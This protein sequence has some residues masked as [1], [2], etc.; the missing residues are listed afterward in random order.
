M[1]RNYNYPVFCV[2]ILLTCIM[3]VRRRE[4]EEVITQNAEKRYVFTW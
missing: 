2:F 4:K 3:Y 1:T